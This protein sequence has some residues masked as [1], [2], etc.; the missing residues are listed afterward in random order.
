MVR[1]MLVL[2]P[3]MCVLS[4][5]GVSAT[6]NSY[7]KNLDSSKRDKKAKKAD[8]TYPIKNEVSTRGLCL[9]FGSFHLTLTS[10]TCLDGVVIIRIYLCQQV[11][12]SGANPVY[13]L[14]MSTDSG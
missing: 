7:M 11:T 5:I 10:L 2:A 9:S 13:K 4:G 14:S 12:F 8:G 1:L 6:L 3:V